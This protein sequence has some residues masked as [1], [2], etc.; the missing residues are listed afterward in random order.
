VNTKPAPKRRSVWLWVA[1][2]LYV[3]NL[4]G[5]FIWVLAKGLGQP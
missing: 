1:V 2:A 3:S 4:L 5:W